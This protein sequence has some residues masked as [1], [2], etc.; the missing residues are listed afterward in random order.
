[1]VKIVFISDLQLGSEPE[2]PVTDRHRLL[3]LE[4]ICSIGVHHDILLIGG[5]LFSGAEISQE[6]VDSVTTLFDS[7]SK[8]KTAVFISP[9]P[10]EL[11]YCKRLEDNGVVTL[12]D[13]SHV[14]HT[15]NDETIII[16]GSDIHSFEDIEVI[17]KT[18]DEGIHIGLLNARFTI[19]ADQKPFLPSENSKNPELDFYALGGN[20]PF[21]IYRHNGRIKSVQCGSSEPK[22]RSELGPRYAASIEIDK[23]KI[24]KLSRFCVNTLEYQEHQI[25][26]SK[27]KNETELLN[28][29]T[30]FSGKNKIVR[31][32]LTGPDIWKEHSIE[33]I[34]DQFFHLETINRYD[35]SVSSLINKFKDENSI[36]GMFYRKMENKKNSGSMENLD[37]E[38]LAQLLNRMNTRDDLSE[39]DICSL[40]NA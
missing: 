18:E 26:C 14:K 1:M 35:L 21:K 38:F 36:R 34:R 24:D 2:L 32:I 28:E 30:G 40:Y 39:G 37:K 8:E 3:T 10:T 15:V 27:H 23:E 5:N 7:L 33:E 12:Q 20:H 25:D 4:K 13:G 16:Y 6:L 22:T 11:E 19:A 17:K 29:C 9:S 31:L